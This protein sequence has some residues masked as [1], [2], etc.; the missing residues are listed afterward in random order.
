M[1][2]KEFMMQGEGDAWLNR[3]RDKLGLHDPV[4]DIIESMQ[5]RPT[6]ILEVGC[7]DGWRLEKLRARYG[8]R[9]HGVE[10]SME[11]GI[12]AAGRRVPVHQMTASCLPVVT[13]GFDLIIY[14][15]CL[16]LTD[17]KD[18]FTIVAEGDRAL[19][20]GGFLIIHDF[21]EPQQAYAKQY[22]HHPALKAY[23][24]AF[25]QFWL[26]SPLYISIGADY[27]GSDMVRVLMKRPASSI[28]V[29]P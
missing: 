26:S 5:L 1:M 29:Q 14:G 18:W 22:E 16:Y 19:A 11:A 3:N 8:A 4:S 20:D 13:G 25:S 21:A 9:V 24:V 17:P 6:S 27:S 7:A 23:H 12:E 28:P 2:Q 15:F 10:P